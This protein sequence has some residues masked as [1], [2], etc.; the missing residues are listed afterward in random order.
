MKQEQY[1]C[2]V[3]GFNMVNFHPENCPFCGAPKKKF[4]TA[5][6]CSARFKVISS[7]VN[8]KVT[9]LNSQPDL[10]YEHAAYR[11]ETDQGAIWIDCPSS[12]DTSL[13]RVDTILFTHHHF[14]GAVNLYREYFAAKVGIHQAD[15]NHEICRPFSFDNLFDSNFSYRGIEAFHLNGH[16]P[17]FTFY[18]FEETLFICD[19]FFL[20]GDGMKLNP[21][22]P[23]DR[24]IGGSNQLRSFLDGRQISTVCGYNYV[25]DYPEWKRRFDAG[26]PFGG[27]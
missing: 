25:I 6:E 21:F 1:V 5:K 12:F 26:A 10:G 9:R 19:Y 17:G 22:G 13:P 4:I 20:T 18:I 11:L 2:L 23:A 3:C 24:T 15:S 16:T 14:L 8:K 27:F 7:P